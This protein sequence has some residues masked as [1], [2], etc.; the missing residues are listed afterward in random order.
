MHVYIFLKLLKV[1]RALIDCL[2][3]H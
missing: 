1:H 2:L 3:I